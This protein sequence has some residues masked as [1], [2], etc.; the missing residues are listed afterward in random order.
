MRIIAVDDEKPAL[1]LI[2]ECIRDADMSASVHCFDSP[3]KALEF[4][5]T[6]EFDVAF[7]DIEMPEISGIALAKRLKLINHHVQIIFVTAYKDYAFDAY[8]LNAKGY[9]LK[10]VT[11]RDIKNKLDG[12]FR[13]NEPEA[14]GMYASTFGQ[15]DFFVDG[16]PVK[17]R[18]SKSKEML[19]YLIDQQGK[20]VTRKDM[21][22]VLFE[23]RAYDDMV[24]DYIK[25]IF[26]D[27]K[28]SLDNSGIGDIIIKKYN[29][30]AVDTSRFVCD[31]YEYCRDNPDYINRFN[32]AYMSQYSWGE[33][34]L[35]ELI[36]GSDMHN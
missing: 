26:R 21:A 16:V 25:K 29:Y 7:L 22:L 28:A 15:F 2:S 36:Y 31:M 30:Y 24:Q 12:I 23:D 27:L 19:A 32:G 33:S 5:K 9:L 35:G 8:Q 6:T 11:V 20:G 4:A 3:R 17:F 18:R 13:P 10:P 34:K 1:E 14:S